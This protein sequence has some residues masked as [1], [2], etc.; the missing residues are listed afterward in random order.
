[1]A[2]FAAVLQVMLLRAWLIDYTSTT[3]AR[4]HMSARAMTGLSATC[5]R[6]LKSAGQL[7]VLHLIGREV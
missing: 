3:H 1:M 6:T 7:V 2:E 5:V 4:R